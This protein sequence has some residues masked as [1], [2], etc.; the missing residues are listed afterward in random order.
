MDYQINTEEIT[1]NEQI[2]NMMAEQ[3]IELDYMLPDYCPEVFKVLRAQMKPNILSERISGNRLMID[4]VA[5]IT[6][7]YLS[8]NS[9]KLN[10]IEQKQA[11]TKT[12]ELGQECDGCFVS[13]RAKCESFSC[14][15][16]NSRRLEMR[17]AIGLG[18]AVYQNRTISAV[19]DCPELQIHRKPVTACDRKFY[20][21]KEFT[22]R[23]EL[24]V[25]ES[26]PP[27]REIVDYSAEA[28]FG[29]YKLLANKVICKGELRLHTIYLSE[30]VEQ[31]ELMEHSIPLSQIMDCEGVDEDD[32]CAC[33]FEVVKYDLD[34]QMEEDGKC[35][36]FTVEIGVRVC[37]EAAKN[38]DIMAVDDCY[39]TSCEIEAEAG[40]C[41]V[42]ALLG[43]LKKSH[44][45]K[46]PL[47]LNQGAVSLIYDLSCHATNI[48]YQM[49]SGRLMV[50][51]SL[52]VGILAADSENMPM[53]IEQGI[54]CEIEVKDT[55]VDSALSF[56]P[57][58]TVKTADYHMIST[59]EIELRAELEVYGLLYR[60]STVRMITGVTAMEDM[61]KVRED[62]AALRIYF[63]DERESVWDVAKRYNTSVAAILEQN[64]IDDETLSAG[65][66]ILIPIMD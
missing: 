23:E 40:E 59:E 14:R 33:R 6:V 47:H 34:L 28:E 45:Q 35:T 4:G 44:V 3:S 57:Q 11:F 41:T 52:Q 8:E 12:V 50:L 18:I 42:E 31:P 58:I 46:C 26:R 56:I 61:P 48:S 60:R 9:C 39:S 10:R 24:R 1:M 27:I 20:V 13:I 19:C 64:E 7:I 22:I 29:D 25:G 54:P 51:C 49:D 15:A 2:A 36:A 43:E 62:D 5:D 30:Q 21:S 63:A 37:C 38:R 55:D 16:Q 53:W 65:E 17:G 32:I 66:M